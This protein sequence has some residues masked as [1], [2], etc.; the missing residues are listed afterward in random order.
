M[1]RTTL[2]AAPDQIVAEMWR[3]VL[4][5]RGVPALIRAGDTSTFLGVTAYPCRLLVDEEHLTRARQILREELGVE[6]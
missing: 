1:S 2:A 6:V 3:N 5:E 4:A